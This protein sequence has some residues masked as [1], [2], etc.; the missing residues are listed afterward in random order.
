MRDSK[1]VKLSIRY[2]RS[3]ILLYTIG[4]AAL[5]ILI[6]AV[7][8]A[9]WNPHMRN[10][11]QDSLPDLIRALLIKKE[12]GG[13]V[14]ISFRESDIWF[15]LERV[16]GSDVSAV[17]ALRIPR[18]EWTDVIVDKLRD[19][20]ESNGFDYRDEDDNPSLIG[21]VWIPIEDIWSKSSGAKGAHAARLLIDAIGLGRDAKFDADDEGQ[22]SRRRFVRNMD[23]NA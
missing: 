12:N 3:Q 14:R 11:G 7:V 6:V 16:S 15:S 1:F 2:R 22:P 23:I 18:R 8:V 5:L 21:R 13:F 10:L 4:L 19:A 9:V 20:F 17:L